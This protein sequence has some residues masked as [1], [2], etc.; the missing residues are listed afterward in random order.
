MVL[1]V[2]K[3]LQEKSGGKL[4][5]NRLKSDSLEKHLVVNSIKENKFEVNVK[6]DEI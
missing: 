3:N 2:R 6:F 4:F 1:T 5:H